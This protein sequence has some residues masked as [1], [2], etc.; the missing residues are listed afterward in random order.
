M[1]FKVS[2]DL[3][4]VTKADGILYVLEVEVDGKLVVKV[5]LTRRSDIC[6]R[7]CEI[8]TSYFQSYRYFPYVR[9]KKFSKV[10]NVYAKEQFILKYF[11]DCKYESAKKFSGCEELLDVDVG[12]VVELYEQLVEEDR[13]DT[14][15]RRR[16][17][18]QMGRAEGAGEG[19]SV[20]DGGSNAQVELQPIGVEP[21]AD[22]RGTPTKKN[23][24][25]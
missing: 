15:K 8:T 14:K 25:D 17:A 21:A 4:N 10:M 9:P 18:K 1:N 24:W 12:V 19:A 23:W 16:E 5:G 13:E 3:E 7:V 11:K 2:H 20:H 22:E 6:D